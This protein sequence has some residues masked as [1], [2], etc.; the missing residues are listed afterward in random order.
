MYDSIIYY[1]LIVPELYNNRFRVRLAEDIDLSF[2]SSVF[3]NQCVCKSYYIVR[4]A[5]TH[6]TSPLLP[7]PSPRSPPGVAW[8]GHGQWQTSHDVIQDLAIFGEGVFRSGRRWR[9]R[10]GRWG[11][12]QTTV[13]KGNHGDG[14]VYNWLDL[15]EKI[16][17]LHLVFDVCFRSQFSVFERNMDSR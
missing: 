4:F 2:G 8:H 5:C 7:P 13:T 9:G 14:S 10:G 6:N 11:G 17:M 1:K 12:V 3:R 16:T 15:H